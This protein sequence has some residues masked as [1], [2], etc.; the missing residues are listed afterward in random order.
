ML[1]A[2][3]TIYSSS[4]DN[5]ATE[6]SES[7]SEE[8][9]LSNATE[10]TEGETGQAT[11][12]DTSSEEEGEEGAPEPPASADWET[13]SDDT[14]EQVD[15][16]PSEQDEE[17]TPTGQQP[18]T[19]QPAEEEQPPTEQPAV[20]EQPPALTEGQW[21]Y[22]VATPTCDWRGTGSCGFYHR[23]SNPDFP[24]VGRAGVVGDVDSEEWGS[25]GEW[26][27]NLNDSSCNFN[28]NGCGYFFTGTYDTYTIQALVTVPTPVTS[29]DAG[30]FS[31]ETWVI[32]GVP[33]SNGGTP[34]LGYEVTTNPGG[35]TCNTVGRASIAV[36][37]IGNTDEGC[38]MGVLP[39]GS[40]ILSVVAIN[41]LGSGL[42]GTS[43][44][45][46]INFASGPPRWLEGDALSASAWISWG[47]PIDDCCTGWQQYTVSA[48]PGNQTC[49]VPYNF[50]EEYNVRKGC[51][52]TGLT[53]GVQYTFSVVVSGVTDGTAWVSPAATIDLTPGT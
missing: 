13:E 17:E 16:E 22:N 19:E 25:V 23:S 35:E 46:E 1:V 11:E 28:G 45:F 5:Q 49:T 14:D 47:D 8:A 21:L 41:A 53:N 44:D 20:E 52:V 39:Q 48:S 32:W 12:E 24:Y 36:P 29:V 2:C 51:T 18:P 50:P 9:D 26:A 27:Y 6:N 3:L 40:H 43:D 30:V 42:A 15:P 31:G 38:R 34:I 7:Q 37:E 4:S 10:S 33:V